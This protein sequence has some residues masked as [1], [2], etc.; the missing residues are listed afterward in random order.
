MTIPCCLT[1]ICNSYDSIP[2]H[3]IFHYFY[4]MKF[5]RFLFVMYMAALSV[6]PCYE[7]TCEGEVCMVNETE[8]STNQEEGADPCTP[9]C[10]SACCS[11]QVLGV[12]HFNDALDYKN[13]V[14]QNS[15]YTTRF[16]PLV[17]VSIWQP[18]R[19]V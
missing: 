3:A 8:S 7:Y 1:C 2:L 17:I 16:T 9:F 12:A 6:Y 10:I 4:A 5:I 15:S 19:L 18:P 13:A 11:L 14:T